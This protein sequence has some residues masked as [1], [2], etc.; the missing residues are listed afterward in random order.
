MGVSPLGS[1][2]RLAR[3]VDHGEMRPL[4]SGWVC[5]DGYWTLIAVT[6]APTRSAVPRGF[7]EGFPF[8]GEGLSVWSSYRSCS[9]RQGET[10]GEDEELRAGLSIMM[11][12]MFSTQRRNSKLAHLDTT[13]KMCCQSM[14]VVSIT[15]R[16]TFRHLSR[17]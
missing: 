17:V 10:D 12:S 3:S 11:M 6:V 14:R 13:K 9:A 5:A 8:W 7:G 15:N 2:S 4:S 16:T 1:P